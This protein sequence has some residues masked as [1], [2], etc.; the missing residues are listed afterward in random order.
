MLANSILLT[1]G[2][3]DPAPW[4]QAIRAGDPDRSLQVWPDLTEPAAIGYALVWEPPDG[5]LQQCP[6]LKVI[7][8]LGAG[9]DRLLSLPD[10]PRVPLVRVVNPDLT[11]RMSE[12]VTLQVLIHH[13]RQ[14]A[15][16]RQQAARIW[17]ELD[18]PAA[19]EIRVGIMGLGVLGRDSATTLRRLGFQVAGW[20]RT[21]TDLPDIAC[22][23]GQAMLERFLARTDI[24]V[25]LLPLTAQTRGILSSALFD[26]LARDGALGGPVLINAGRGALQK[27]D[28]I[29]AALNNGTLVGASLDVFEKEPLDAGSP[30]WSL[31]NVVIT[32]HSAATSAPRALVPPILDQIKAFEGGALLE[33]VVDRE[34]SY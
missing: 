26:K 8:S 16:D 9:V 2:S 12:W 13:R 24:L 19:R 5:L 25:C 1:V 28:D 29:L 23:H 3:W 7:F 32:P 31:P 10:L 15:Y 34:R 18:Q 33:N 4:V 11:Q 22:F 17:K 27:E 30:L 21:P 20:S 14:R 6:N